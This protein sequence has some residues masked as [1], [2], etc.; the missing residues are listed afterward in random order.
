MIKL[1][2]IERQKTERSKF[3]HNNCEECTRSFYGSAFV[4]DDEGVLVEY[5]WKC[6]A[7]I[8]KK[9]PV[10]RRVIFDEDKLVKYLEERIQKIAEGKNEEIN[11]AFGFMRMKTKNY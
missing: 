10:F 2:P 6:I 5:C 11:R 9:I 1:N 8:S 4:W 7:T 3:T